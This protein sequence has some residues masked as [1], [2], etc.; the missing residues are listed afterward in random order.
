[1]YPYFSETRGR[2]GKVILSG[3]L[4]SLRVVGSSRWWRWQDLYRKTKRNGAE[5]G[6]GCDAES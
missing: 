5:A 1:M 4:K 2:P 6:G 3:S